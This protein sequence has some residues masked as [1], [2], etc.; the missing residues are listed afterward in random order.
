M[1]NSIK[2]SQLMH[3]VAG[4]GLNVNQE[5]FLSDAPNPIS[6]R[7]ITGAETPLVDLLP[8]LCSG[9]EKRYLQLRAGN[10]T[11]IKK[12]YLNKL[13]RFMEDHLFRRPNG[14]VFSGRIID[15]LPEGKLLVLHDR[16]EEA[17]GLK[18]IGFVV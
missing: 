8:A 9:L 13:Y 1:Q 10:V 3:T 14:D 7:Q 6:L 18:E 15:V 5:L 2:G 11:E 17:F 4:I 12:D 16:G